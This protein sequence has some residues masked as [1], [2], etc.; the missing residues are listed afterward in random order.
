[1]MLR[2]AESKDRCISCCSDK[3]AKQIS[4]DRNDG[5]YRGQN[6]VT[7]SLCSDCLRLLAQEF[8]PYS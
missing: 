7:F 3:A 2:V 8:R 5:V 1:M 6:I 4:I